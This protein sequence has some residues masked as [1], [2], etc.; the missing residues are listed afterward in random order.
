MSDLMTFEA[1]LADAFDRF[2][3]DAPVEVDPRAMTRLVAGDAAGRADGIWGRARVRLATGPTSRIAYLL[4]ALAMMLA[5][6]AGA[7]LI[8][9]GLDHES[10][11]PAPSP[12][13]AIAIR[14]GPLA[15]AV[16]DGPARP[17]DRTYVMA[18]DGS[19]GHVV[20]QGS[21]PAFSNDGRVLSYVSG[22][23]DLAQ[24]VVAAA[25]GTAAHVV[26]GIGAVA[27][28]LSPDGTGIA[29]FKSIRPITSADGNVTVAWT[30]ELWITPVAGG[31]GVRV[32]GVSSDPNE[33]YTEPVWSPDGRQIAFGAEVGVF[34]AN[35]GGTFSSG[36]DLVD[37]DGSHLRQLTARPDAS[38]PRW[39]PDGRLI[40]YV[41]LPD[42]SRLPTLPAANEA[43]N[44][45]P[46]DIF[47]IGADG[48]GDRDLTSSPGSKPRRTGRRTGRSSRT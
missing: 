23:D 26:P 17:R 5:I 32:L 35:G 12:S 25:D 2:A 27:H 29:W 20:A 28:A 30:D 36:I 31:A 16:A 45:P 4:V 21:C 37:A 43:P 24:L 13:P 22:V 3:A 15:Y 39:S 18:A 11:V 44:A 7:L 14:N 40:A 8:G 38:H 34:D 48:T 33:T 47:A 42:G 6:V 41:G 46:D 9:G 19:G 1:R 10:V